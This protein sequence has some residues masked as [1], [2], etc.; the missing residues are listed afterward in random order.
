MGEGPGAGVSGYEGVP[1]RK[2][3]PVCGM[4]IDANEH[5]VEYQKMH[6]AF[7]SRQCRERFLKNPHLY[8]GHGGHKAPK[9]EGRVVY[10]QRRLKLDRP[11]SP[12]MAQTVRNAVQ[13]MMGIERLEIE[14]DNVKVTYDLLQATEVQVE[15]AIACAGA[16]LGAGWSERLRRAFVHYLEET[17][18][19]SLA[20]SSST[21]GHGH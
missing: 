19:E 21:H 16:A 13:A 7:C 8:I 20:A 6:F 17:E 11:L 4:M 12:E 9:Q 2:R 18:I 10:K 15:S 1:E 14:G 3:D 5:A